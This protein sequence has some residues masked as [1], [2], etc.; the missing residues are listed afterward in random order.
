MG[1]SF[2]IFMCLPLGFQ[3]QKDIVSSLTYS[4]IF[5]LEILNICSERD[6]LPL[7]W[8]RDF[9]EQKVNLRRTD[10]HG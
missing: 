5:G 7:G 1:V 4:D 9:D 10:I 8:F 6:R 3:R 2:A